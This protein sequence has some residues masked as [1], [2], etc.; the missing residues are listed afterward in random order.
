AQL[1]HHDLVWAIQNKAPD[2]TLLMARFEVTALN[3]G[4]QKIVADGYW[5]RNSNASVR[6]W[7]E[8]EDRKVY[9][10]FMSEGDT[11]GLYFLDAIGLV[12]L[13]DCAGLILYVRWRSKREA[14]FAPFGFRVA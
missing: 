4:R 6:S 3:N 10:R 1:P 5:M 2:D 13:L 7:Y 11:Y 14:G 9:P 8:A 12:A